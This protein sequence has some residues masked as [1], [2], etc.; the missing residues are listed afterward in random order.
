MYGFAS[1]AVLS[2]MDSASA[3]RMV[4]RAANVGSAVPLSRCASA[5]AVPTPAEGSASTQRCPTATSA[6]LPSLSSVGSGPVAGDAGGS[7][8][9]STAAASATPPLAGA[10]RS[11]GASPIVYVVAA[12]PGTCGC[13]VP[14]GDSDADADVGADDQMPFATPTGADA[15]VL[16][17]LAVLGVR[18]SAASPGSGGGA[19]SSGSG[20]G[21]GSMSIGAVRACR[22]MPAAALKAAAGRADGTVAA[23]VGSSDDE[24]AAALVL[25]GDVAGAAA[26]VRRPVGR[27]GLAVEVDV[28]LPAA[29][30]GSLVV[31]CE[32]KAAGAGGAGQRRQPVRRVEVDMEGAR[33]GVARWSYDEVDG[34]LRVELPRPSAAALAPSAGACARTIRI[35]L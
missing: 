3:M 25:D 33:G 13:H 9:G 30:A 18:A 14:C 34:M 27:L 31:F 16:A 26:A 20:G 1:D 5:S 11:I 24:D 17:S 23:T 32:A 29:A 7:N 6:T 28:E 2:V 12:V 22:I 35:Y 19:A 15:S 8:G 4:P 21:S 10:G